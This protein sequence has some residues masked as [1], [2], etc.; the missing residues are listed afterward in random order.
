MTALPAHSELLEPTQVP[1]SNFLFLSGRSENIRSWGFN[2]II[3]LH[4]MAYRIR[5]V[6]SI[7]IYI[8]VCQC[9]FSLLYL[10]RSVGILF[11]CLHSMTFLVQGHSL[12]FHIYTWSKPQLYSSS[13]NT[14]F[15]PNF[16]LSYKKAI[17]VHVSEAVPAAMA[18]LTLLRAHVLPCTTTSDM[19]HGTEECFH[20]LCNDAE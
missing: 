10:I 1:I 15:S 14:V 7:C 16:C 2:F 6:L 13:D 17:L 8:Y 3:Q 9:Y 19:G 5:L 4:K 11:L 18:S 12:T 20:V